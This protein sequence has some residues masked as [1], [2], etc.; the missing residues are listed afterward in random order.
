MKKKHIEKLILQYCSKIDSTPYILY[1]KVNG[2][3]LFGMDLFNGHEI[4]IT[5]LTRQ[6]QLQHSVL[7]IDSFRTNNPPLISNPIYS[8]YIYVESDNSVKSVH[9]NHRLLEFE[10]CHFS[11]NLVHIGLTSIIDIAPFD[12]AYLPNTHIPFLLILLLT[13]QENECKFT[14]FRQISWNRSIE[15]WFYI[16][17]V[18]N[19]TECSIKANFMHCQIEYW[20]WQSSFSDVT[21][22]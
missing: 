8:W 6:H 9:R 15:M 4:V 5:T 13:C 3:R 17:N 11:Q 2:Q 22:H 20:S 1:C 21:L 10:P 14:I 19:V 12:K 7:F 18:K 16:N